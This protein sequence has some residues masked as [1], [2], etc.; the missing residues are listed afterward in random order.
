MKIV[1]IFRGFPGLGRVVSGVELLHYFQGEHGAEIFIYTYLQG[2]VLLKQYNIQSQFSISPLDISSIGIIPVSKYGENIINSIG[3]IKPDFVLVD[4]EPLMVQAIKLTYPNTHVI[5]LLNP[6][7]VENPMNQTSSQLFFNHYFSLS[8]LAI[9][10]GLRKVNNPG[11]Y[12]NFHSVNTIIRTEILNI[13]RVI[14]SKQIYCILGGGTV[15][16]QNDFLESTLKIANLCFGLALELADYKI[17]I[18]CSS[19]NVYEIVNENIKPNQPANLQLIST[20]KPPA[21]YY[22]NSSLIITRAG[23]NSLSELLFLNIPAISFISGCSFRKEEQACNAQ[24]SQNLL[25]KSLPTDIQLS[26]FVQTC[27]D[28]LYK[29]EI[30]D[31]KNCFLPG[32]KVAIELILN[33]LKNH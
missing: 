10:H 29:N 14:K 33:Y 28:L 27:K 24:H 11:I 20:I 9:V 32:N 21:D 18:Q 13:S 1:G 12:K 16:V 15:N 4:G 2:E 3:K 25:I 22:S 17:T 6:S 19:S 5:S 30:E 23:R 7:D 8:D 31:T 26:Q